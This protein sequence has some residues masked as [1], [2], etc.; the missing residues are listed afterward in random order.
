MKDNKEITEI[1]NTLYSI[2]RYLV[3]HE[4]KSKIKETDLD[5]I[6]LELRKVLELIKKLRQ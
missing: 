3:T 6:E 2:I 5:N 4:K 1:S